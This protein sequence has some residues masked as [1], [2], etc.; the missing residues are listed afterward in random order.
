MFHTWRDPNESVMLYNKDMI[1]NIARVTPSEWDMT[2]L[3]ANSQLS[4]NTR[5]VDK[6]KGKKTVWRLKNVELEPVD[7]S[8]YGVFFSGDCYLV[9]YQ[10]E[11]GDI[12]YYWLGSHS[13]IKEQTA[14]T[15]QTIVKDNNDFSGNAVQVR[16]VQGKECLHFLTMFEGSAI[17]YKGDHQ[18]V[19]PTTFL[20]Q[21]TGTNE[22]NTKAIQVN[23]SASCLNSNDVFIVKKKQAYFI[24]CGKGSS[25]N[26]REMAGCIA[27]R[28]SND[29]YSVIFEGQE[30]DEFW[31][32]IGGK[33]EYAS[34]EKLAIA[35]DLMPGRLFQISNASGIF[36][37]EEI[38]NWSQ[39]DLVPEDVMLLDVRDTI[40][41]WV[42][43]KANREE[44]KESTNLALQYLKADPSQRDL[45]TPI[46]V[47]KQGH[48]PVTFTGFFGPWDADL[49]KGHRTFEELKKQIELE[50]S[51]VPS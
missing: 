23:M 32:T 37:L 5:L 48:E 8:M 44:M 42:G 25:E 22:T 47:L 2:S 36:T 31:S 33:Q 16:L 6:G 41:L 34:S 4:A 24:W 12:L 1:E 15:I 50:N 45:D 13:S 18:D 51:G 26:E 38:P 3:H 17:I 46:V 10:Y 20:L 30:T 7:E 19:L 27:R 11:G 9:H 21:V 35:T 28:I 29:G 40:F 14:V 39:Q 43:E 49:W